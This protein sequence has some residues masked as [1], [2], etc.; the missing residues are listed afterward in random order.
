[1][2][3]KINTNIETLNL[4][5]DVKKKFKIPISSYSDAIVEICKKILKIRQSYYELRDL[6][7]Q[8]L[9]IVLRFIKEQ[10]PQEISQKLEIYQ[11]LLLIHEKLEEE[12]RNNNK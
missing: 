8:T 11:D 9:N 6:F 4:I 3:I 7:Y 12:M 5:D 10:V 1:M 2:V